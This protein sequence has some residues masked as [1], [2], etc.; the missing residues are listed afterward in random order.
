LNGLFVLVLSFLFS[1]CANF[2]RQRRREADFQRTVGNYRTTVETLRQEKQALLQLQEGGEG[3]K[4]QILASSQKALERAAQL[5]TDAAAL[6]K[7]EAQTILD[8]LENRAHRHL[9][10][11]LES[12]LP[13]D[14]AGTEIAAMKGE[15][16]TA[17]VIGKASRSLEGIATVFAR[18]IRPALVPPDAGSD[19]GTESTSLIIGD[20]TK[21]EIGAMFHQAQLAEA[22]VDAS[23]GL[24]RFLSA[25]QW[26]DVL[27]AEH[28]AELAAVLGHLMGGIDVSLSDL[29][30]SLKQEGMLTPELLS[31]ETF[32]QTVETSIQAIRS[33]VSRAEAPLVPDD[34]NPPGWSLLRDASVAKFS[35]LGS[36]AA[37]SLAI[38]DME[39][40]GVARLLAEMYNRAEQI[41][42]QASSLVRR[43]AS[44]DVNDGKLIQDVSGL[45]TD[46]ERIS[47]GYLSA[48]QKFV[49]TGDRASEF[50]TV[51]DSVL[52]EVSGISSALRSMGLISGED[53]AFHALS[54]EAAD[55]WEQVAHTARAVRG[56]DGDIEDVNYAVRARAVEQRLQDAVEKVPLLDSATTKI[57][58]LEKVGISLVD[59]PA[60]ENL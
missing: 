9:S 4:N 26:P 11:R 33:E 16:T 2:N 59:K 55:S 30:K 20:E 45:M 24:I 38:R 15:L 37:F 49:V 21:Q 27:D 35:C 14:V 12:L 53:G 32:R 29:L 28:S 51:L 19:V 25:T 60:E 44:I 47:S 3:E 50:S 52:K 31:V 5:V 17:K 57:G 56:L 58:N 48:T 41:S 46:W 1:L 23:S 54:P 42:S 7:R 8:D 34:W 10:T 6:R 43:V 36:T 39:Q 22:I 13:P 40:L 18:A